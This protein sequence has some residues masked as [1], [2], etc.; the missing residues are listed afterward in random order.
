MITINQI[1]LDRYRV[2]AFIDS[3]GMG[4]VYRVWDL[5]RNVPLAMKVLHAELAEDASALKHFKREA[6]ALEKLAHPN[7]VP[8]YGLQEYEDSFL[9]LERFV[10]GPSL[11]DILRTYQP[12]LMS[13]KEILTYLKAICSALGYAHH[14]GVVHCDI[15]LGNV[16]LDQTGQIYLTDFGIARHAESTTTTFGSAGTPAYMAPEQIQGKMVTAATDVYA[17]GVLLFEMATGK[18]P[19]RGDEP[20]TQSAG[21]TAGERIRYA[22]LNLAP[23]NP[24]DLNPSVPIGL[25][26]IIQKALSKEPENRYTNSVELFTAACAALGISSAAIPD[27]AAIP[28]SLLAETRPDVLEKPTYDQDAYPQKEQK[29]RIHLPWP[30]VVG[31]ILGLLILTVAAVLLLQKPEGEQALA[32]NVASNASE[33]ITDT[34]APVLVSSATAKPTRTPTETPLPSPTFTPSP[35]PTPTPDTRTTNPIDKAWLIEVPGGE[36]VM[37]S[38]DGVD[39]YFWG[40][41]GPSHFVSVD[42]FKIYQTEVTNA[43]YLACVEAKACPRPSQTKARQS[44]SYFGNP[45]YADYPVIYV[46]HLDAVA[47]CVWAGGRLP[48]EAEWEKAAR[49]TDGRLFLWGNAPASGDQANLCDARCPSSE[50]ESRVNDGFAY[51][52]PVGSF[53]AGASPYGVLDMAGNVLEWVQDWMGTLYYEASPYENPLG[54]ASASRRVARGGSFINPSS[55]IRVVARMGINP[56]ET[57]DTLGFRCVI[58]IP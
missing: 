39:P 7:F 36:F 33:V 21:P 14:N 41:E 56:N 38:D 11:K 34:V 26:E 52:A 12:Q 45:E 23:P 53:P 57:I 48:T 18:R 54:P 3:G 29:K 8:F 20:D 10:D 55:G 19:F 6:R 2:D 27:R 47:Y 5:Q 51:T 16:I 4:A 25:V 35:S 49:G 44:D 37:G 42:A 24:H 40:A 58:P 9:M 13:A 50:R 22:H 43:M 1:L 31:A 15:K 32:Q 17:L 30:A 28:S 46:N